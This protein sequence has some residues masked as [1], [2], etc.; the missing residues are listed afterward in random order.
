MVTAPIPPGVTVPR[1][2][3]RSPF[4]SASLSFS[5]SFRNRRSRWT[6][7]TSAR[8][9]T[10]IIRIEHRPAAEAAAAHAAPPRGRRPRSIARAPRAARRAVATRT[11]R[12]R[13]LSQASDV[14][15]RMPIRSKP[16]ARSPRRPTSRPTRP[17]RLAAAQPA[18]AAATP[19]RR[20]ADR[21]PG[22]RRARSR[23]RKLRRRLSGKGRSRRH[24][25]R[26]SRG[27]HGERA[28]PGERR[29]ERPRGR[30]RVRA[31]PSDPR[32][33]ESCARA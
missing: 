12:D 2:A 10:S 11:R 33:R 22:C 24:A 30:R 7:R 31:A 25:A 29:R 15:T 13:W 20:I 16:R 23:H 6:S 32:S 5:S 9:L 26:S 8:C 3:S 21:I 27:I 19:R 17:S 4:I 14:S 28:A 18:P 1:S